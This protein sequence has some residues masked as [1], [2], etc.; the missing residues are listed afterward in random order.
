M[1][2]QHVNVYNAC[3]VLADASRL[4]AEQL[5][6]RIQNF[7]AVNMELFLET[8]MLEDMP[9]DLIKQLALFAGQKQLEKSPISRSSV[10]VNM[11]LEKHAD[12][13]AL[14]DFPVPLGRR[15]QGISRK[16][17]ASLKS[18]Q[19]GLSNSPKQS[20]NKQPHLRRPPSNDDIFLMDEADTLPPRAM[21]QPL[22]LTS[23]ADSANTQSPGPA[24]PT[25]IPVWKTA[26]VPR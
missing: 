23:S 14:Q 18:N 20:P 4:N 22:P 17:S 16:E 26:S 25:P 10:V 15:S 6:Y 19:A 24:T 12:W 1:I 3:F 9:P 21:E 11:A 8:G 13:L 7:I 5:I 2:L